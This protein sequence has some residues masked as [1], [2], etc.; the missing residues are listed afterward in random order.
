MTESVLVADMPV[1]HS[2]ARHEVLAEWDA[3]GVGECFG[4]EID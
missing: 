4:P 3:H 1:S 2:P